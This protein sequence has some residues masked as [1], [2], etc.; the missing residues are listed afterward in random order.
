M[1]EKILKAG[2]WWLKESCHDPKYPAQTNI[3]WVP[4]TNRSGP[5]TYIISFNPWDNLERNEP[6]FHSLDGEARILQGHSICTSLRPDQNCFVMPKPWRLWAFM[7]QRN[8]KNFTVYL[9]GRILLV[10]IIEKN[11]VLRDAL[12]CHL[13]PGVPK[14]MFE[15]ISVPRHSC[16]PGQGHKSPISS[17]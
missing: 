12:I 2:G 7:W 14:V 13:P 3:Y 15:A 17:F 8:K 9:L 10:G 4:G 6:P 1:K 11:W 16:H 5:L